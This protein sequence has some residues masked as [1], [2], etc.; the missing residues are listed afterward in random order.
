MF[1]KY[2]HIE[3]L[4][5]QAVRGIEE[6]K[7]YVF[8]KIDGTNASVWMEGTEVKAGSRNREL[9]EEADNAGFYR[10]IQENKELYKEALVGMN[11]HLYGEWLVPRTLKTYSGDAWRKFYAFDVFDYVLEKYIPYDVYAPILK[12]VGIEVIE[13]LLVIEN[14]TLEDFKTAL[15]KNKFLLG[16]DGT[17]GE[18]V[19]IKNYKY[20]NKYGEVKWAKII[21]DE[22]SQKHRQKPA[23][24]VSLNGSASRDTDDLAEKYLT[25]AFVEKEKAKIAPEGWENKYIPKLLGVIWYTF[26]QEELWDLIKK[27][28]NPTINFRHLQGSVYKRTISLLSI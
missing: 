19:V 6:G 8:P 13:P 24:K 14:A 11:W 20:C 27:E 7:T 15:E 9:S 5:N 12:G 18:G 22:F 21:T 23:K 26:V 16:S 1:R 25:K 2:M 10:H 4:G 3:R 28:K 17:V